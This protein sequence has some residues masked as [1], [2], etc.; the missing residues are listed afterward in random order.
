[1]TLA[2]WLISKRANIDAT[3][4]VRFI[5]IVRMFFSKPLIRIMDIRR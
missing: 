2:I 4:D 1:M 3:D 5:Q